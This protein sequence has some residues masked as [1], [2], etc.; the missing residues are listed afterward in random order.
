MKSDSSTLVVLQ[1]TEEHMLRRRPWNRGF[2]PSALKA[3]EPIAA[4]RV[5]LL[6]QRLSEETGV[7]SL[8]QWFN[9]FT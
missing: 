7:V 9:Y 8:E 4:Y 1:D 3:Y 6:R 5:D 2:G